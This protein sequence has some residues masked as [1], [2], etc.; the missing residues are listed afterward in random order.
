MNKE[1]QRQWKEL[2]VSRSSGPAKGQEGLGQEQRVN[3]WGGLSRSTKGMEMS[4]M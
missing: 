1:T 2:L 3:I 4:G